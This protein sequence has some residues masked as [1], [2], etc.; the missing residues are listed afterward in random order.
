MRY[1]PTSDRN[2][3]GTKVTDEGVVRLDKVDK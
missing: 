1:Q 2:D 3:A